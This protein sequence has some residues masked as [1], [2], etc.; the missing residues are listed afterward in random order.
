MAAAAGKPL[1]LRLWV[2]LLAIAGIAGLAP[3]WISPLSLPWIIIP[4]IALAAILWSKRVHGVLFS[5]ITLLAVGWLLPALATYF[6]PKW[7]LIGKTWAV[8]LASYLAFAAGY[9]IPVSVWLRKCKLQSSRTFSIRVWDKHKFRK[10]LNV[11][12]ML[13]M[14]GFGIN[15]ANVYRHGGLSI[16]LHM[17]FR[18]V[19]R[20]FAFFPLTNYL[21]FLNG[22]VV[23]LGI[24]YLKWHGRASPVLLQ[25]S[26]SF[27]ALFFHTVVG[28]VLFP[29][30]IA[31]Y[32]YWFVGKR[33]PIRALIILLL[34]ALLAFSIVSFGRRYITRSQ[35][36]LKQTSLAVVKRMYRYM[37][38]NYANL[39]MELM[40]REEHLWGVM[41]LMRPILKLMSLS[42]RLPLVRL[43]LPG[44]QLYLVDG[45]YNAGTYLRSFFIDFGLGGVLAGPFVL[46]FITTIFFGKF[47][48]NPTLRN[49][50]LYSVIATMI[51]FTFWFNEFARIQFWYFMA[52]IWFVDWL[53]TKHRRVVLKRIRLRE[54]FTTGPAA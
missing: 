32:A 36:T 18:E 22:L 9:F 38:P 15:S 54:G 10:A 42:G 6:E 44:T 49:L 4:V 12:S 37:A 23:V 50:L 39:Q 17:G 1:D 2:I 46:G 31:I 28:T 14:L 8:I 34:L 21:Y 29:A 45:G 3:L 30:V 35:M 41:T 33:L 5:P 53:L 25:T 40:R 47:V 51:T 7:A 19:E 48:L 13:G 11:L 52:V 16:Y 27:L 24:V 20:I 26:A 43:R